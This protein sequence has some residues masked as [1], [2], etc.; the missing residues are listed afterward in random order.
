MTQP[1]TWCH[2]VASSKAL[3]PSGPLLSGVS[4]DPYLFPIY[5][6]CPIGPATEGLGRAL[7]KMSVVP[8]LPGTE[9]SAEIVAESLLGL[10]GGCPS[11]FF[12]AVSHIPVSRL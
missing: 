9:R 8:W 12:D 7:G 2:G 11:G 6:L 10:S 3:G 4:A 1:P 5:V